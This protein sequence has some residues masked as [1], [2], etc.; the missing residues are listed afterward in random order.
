MPKSGFCEAAYQRPWQ[1]IQK[2]NVDSIT[3]I[4]CTA[5]VNTSEIDQYVSRFA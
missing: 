3:I 4:N 5:L 1:K 2:N